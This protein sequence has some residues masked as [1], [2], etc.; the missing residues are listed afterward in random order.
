MHA[1]GLQAECLIE[2]VPV[3]VDRD[4]YIDLVGNRWM[5]VLST[6]TD[7]ELTSGLD[8]MRDRYPP[9]ELQFVDR[10]AFVAGVR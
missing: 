8:E 5:S 9:G 4:Q 10:F 6:F 2:E 1:A 3:V 7:E